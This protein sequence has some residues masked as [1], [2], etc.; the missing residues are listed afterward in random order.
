MPDDLSL[1]QIVD[2]LRLLEEVKE[3]LARN[4]EGKG[5]PAEQLLAQVPAWATK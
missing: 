4:P 1:K 5:I 3:R 2:E